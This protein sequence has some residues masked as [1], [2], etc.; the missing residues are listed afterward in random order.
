M[1]GGDDP[2][3][4]DRY[5]GVDIIDYA[6]TPVGLRAGGASA[7]QTERP[8]EWFVGLAVRRRLWLGTLPLP[9][10][11]SASLHRDGVTHPLTFTGVDINSICCQQS[12]PMTA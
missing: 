7:P 1:I 9:L 5:E 12:R 6:V 3:Y 2:L 8:H 11:M 10:A 4:H